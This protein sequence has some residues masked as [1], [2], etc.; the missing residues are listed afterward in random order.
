M[1]SL[2]GAASSKVAPAVAYTPDASLLTV[3][4][5]GSPRSRCPWGGSRAAFLGRHMAAFCG[6]MPFLYVCLWLSF[7]LRTPVSRN[8]G[9]LT[10]PF[11]CQL[12]FR[13]PVSKY[14]GVGASTWGFL[15]FPL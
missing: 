15:E 14:L 7:L 6:L 12:L 11:S 9:H 1:G 13:G 5:A 3:L 10:T 4:E 8:Q 2:A